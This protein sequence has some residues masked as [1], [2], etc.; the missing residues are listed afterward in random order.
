MTQIDTEWEGD[1]NK[2][3]EYE[4]KAKLDWCAQKATAKIIKG[5]AVIDQNT[6][7]QTIDENGK[8]VFFNE[9]LE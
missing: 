8:K 6:G 1:S 7:L 4:N 5:K 9:W 2:K 3:L